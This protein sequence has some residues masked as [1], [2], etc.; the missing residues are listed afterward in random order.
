MKATQ[1]T[2]R[3]VPARFHQGAL[4]NRALEERG[5]PPITFLLG[6]DHAVGQARLQD[7]TV[8]GLTFPDSWFERTAYLWQQPRTIRFV[9]VGR[10]TLGRP[11]L[12]Q[13]WKRR[14][15]VKIVESLW[16]YNPARKG[17]YDATYFGWLGRAEFGLC[18]HEPEWT[19][20][21][22]NMWTYRFAECCLAGAIPVQFRATPLGEKFTAGFYY[23]WDK[24]ATFTFNADAAAANRRLAEERF[25]LP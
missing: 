22:T 6:S 24:D 14:D 23:V 20:S 16:S 25:R 11:K 21:T 7:G 19:A 18:P 12:L 8:V 17:T 5:Q 15:D 13:S 9:F 3:T 10:F 4:L 1:R 2:G